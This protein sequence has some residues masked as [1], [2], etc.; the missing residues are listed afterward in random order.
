VIAR[1]LRHRVR[2]D[3]LA[4]LILGFLAMSVHAESPRFDLASEGSW[5]SW[6]DDAPR[7]ASA[8]WA[9]TS[10]AS[11]ELR[12]L[13][14]PPECSLGILIYRDHGFSPEEPV[15]ALPTA[16]F[17]VDG[18]S[19][20]T[21]DA[22]VFHPAHTPRSRTAIKSQPDGTEV[23]QIIDLLRSGRHVDIQIEPAPEDPERF[24]T[25][26]ER[27]MLDGFDA[28]YARARQLCE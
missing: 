27:F 1:Q 22:W 3:L 4:G 7:G 5:A 23:R 8:F 24:E 16:G 20:Y 13:F 11:S 25:W 10:A 21:A 9:T 2:I 15:Y 19:M 18:E 6:R 26:T 28:M 17:R 12:I 14:V